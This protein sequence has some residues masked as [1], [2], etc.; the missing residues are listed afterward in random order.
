MFARLI[1]RRKAATRFFAVL[2]LGWLAACSPVGLSGPSDRQAPQVRA[3]A[4][5]KVALMVPTGTDDATNDF[6]ARNLENAARM[7][8]S[9]LDGVTIDLRVYS[10]GTTA[11]EAATAAAQAYNDGAMILLGPLFA[12]SANAAG[13]VLANTGINVLAFS[14]NPT[15]AG[16]NVFIL[17]PTFQNTAER[18]VQYSRRN[19]INSYLAVH[20]DD[21]QGNVGRDAVA[22]AVRD[23]GGTLVGSQSY[24]L[25]QDG[26]FAA[27]GSIADTAISSGVD[28]IVLTAGANADLPILATALPERGLDPATT[29][30]IGLT[31]WDVAPQGYAVPGLQG[32][33]FAMPDQTM[34]NIFESRYFAAFGEAPHPVAGLAYDGIAAIGALVAQGDP[35]ALSAA[36]LTQPQG[37]QGTAGIFR[38]L[39]NG[40]NQR[41]LAVATIRNNQVVILEAAPRSFAGAGY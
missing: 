14:N 23:A 19:G 32:G 11:D 1:S 3:G 13:V 39:P 16:G 27:A 33:L 22:S 36:S 15:I 21:L 40:T 9:D 20:A 41:G 37:F 24:P 6:L 31:R 26:I 2:A 8:I 10:S 25:S 4:P 34:T 30:Y 38:L 12:D 5:V 35:N 18:L 7:A 28:A 29:Q 17:G